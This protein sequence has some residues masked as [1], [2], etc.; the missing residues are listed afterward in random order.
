MEDTKK[1]ICI[2]CPMG[3]RLQVTKA[4]NG[5]LLVE[6]NQCNRGQAYAVKELTAPTR[7]L[8]TTVVLKHGLYRRLP[9]RTEEGI[10]KEKLLEAMEVLNRIEVET[11]VLVGDIIIKNLLGTKVN[12][13]ASRSA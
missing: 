7:V 4:E 8:T 12:V 9:V 10:P 2:N 11:P 3:C 6:G 5:E 1:L 13:I